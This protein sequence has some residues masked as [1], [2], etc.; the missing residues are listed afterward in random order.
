VIMNV[1]TR[2]ALSL[3]C[4]VVAAST[5][6]K[7]QSVTGSISGT[8]IDS[9]GASVAGAKVRLISESTSLAREEMTQSNGDFA[10]NAVQPG[11]FTVHVGIQAIHAYRRRT[12]A[13]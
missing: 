12:Q 7:A 6:L 5:P 10:F 13:R 11:V 8:V 3:W 1:Q 2:V 9:T 4:S